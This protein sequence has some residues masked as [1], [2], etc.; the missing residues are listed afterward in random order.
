MKPTQADGT[1]WP[2][3]TKLRANCTTETLR[4]GDALVLKNV[5]SKVDIVI[6]TLRG[7]ERQYYLDKLDVVSLPDKTGK[8][9]VVPGDK[10]LVI[11]KCRDNSIP[12]GVIGIASE[13]HHGKLHY[14]RESISTG[15]TVRGWL[16][17]NDPQFLAI[18]DRVKCELAENVKHGT[19]TDLTITNGPF[20]AGV[21]L[22]TGGY[23]YYRMNATH[24]DLELVSNE[25]ETPFYDALTKGTATKSYALDLPKLEDFIKMYTTPPHFKQE[26]T[27]KTR[28]QRA[29]DLD[30]QV[31][32][33]EEGIKLRNQQTKEANAQD[34]E[35][36][37]ELHNEITV[38]NTY[39]TDHEAV[40][41]DIVT[42]RKCS[43]KQAEAFLRLQKAD[44]KL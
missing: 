18:G 35:K 2:K 41:A 39:D 20:V 9:R 28:T 8:P 43:K 38:L 15:N 6:C 10:V 14:E 4:E 26:S 36:V 27:M 24:Q 31:G 23:S 5:N 42:V 33:L 22:D 13:V 3:G 44:I 1:P 11:G 32:E 30:K 37:Q 7:K 12:V 29:E 40:I 21:A 16:W 34:K 25:E 17:L 19:V